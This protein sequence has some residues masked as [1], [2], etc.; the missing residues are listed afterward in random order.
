MSFIYRRVKPEDIA[1]LSQEDIFGSARKSIFG[2]P[3]V[4]SSIAIMYNM[5]SHGLPTV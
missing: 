2:K 5:C 3:V 1:E 4:V